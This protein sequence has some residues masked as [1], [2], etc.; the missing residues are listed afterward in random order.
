MGDEQVKTISVATTPDGD[1]VT[2][3]HVDNFHITDSGMLCIQLYTDGDPGLPRVNIAVYN[4]M[5]WL[6]VEM[7]EEEGNG[8]PE[9]DAGQG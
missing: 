7:T 5:G 8:E 2:H 6:S 4:V 9:S 1:V 3:E